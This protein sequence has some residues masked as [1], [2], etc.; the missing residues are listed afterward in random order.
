MKMRKNLTFKIRKTDK[1]YI[2]ELSLLQN[3]WF[4]KLQNK[5]I[6][7]FI[8]FSSWYIWINAVSIN[9]LHFRYILCVCVNWMANLVRQNISQW[10]WQF[11]RTSAFQT[12]TIQHI[13][14][15]SVKKKCLWVRSNDD[16]T[17]SIWKCFGIRYEYQRIEIWSTN[18]FVKRSLLVLYKFFYIIKRIQ[19]YSP[20]QTDSYTHSCTL[21]HSHKKKKLKIHTYVF[22]SV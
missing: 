17:C 13:N 22:A 11:S 20:P 8:Y 15:A 6:R 9:S 21:S 12:Q 2:I 7:V 10:H 18:V 19:L 5:P 14:T 1:N 3:I 4:I 16:M